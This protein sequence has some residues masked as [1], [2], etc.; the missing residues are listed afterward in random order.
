[1]RNTVSVTGCNSYDPEEVRPALEAVLKPLG[2]LD[3]V[4]AGMTIVIKANL[5]SMLK[6][7]SAATTHPVLLTELCRM[8]VAK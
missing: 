1:M 7:A 5:V 6:P 2:G 4:K 8:L 3:F